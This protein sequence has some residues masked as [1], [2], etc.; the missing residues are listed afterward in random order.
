MP[1]N[2]SKGF[3]LIGVIVAIFIISIGMIGILDLSQSS[4]RAAYLSQTRLIASGL[5]QE[6]IE[7]VRYMRRFQTEWDDWYD[8]V[9]SGNYR[10]QYNNSNL[11]VFSETPL[12]Y[13]TVSGLYQY[14]SGDD[15]PFYR[16]LTLTK[17]SAD[18]IKVVAEIKWQ[19]SGNWHSL[20]A[21]SRL[22]NWK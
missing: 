20:I 21:E 7:V 3:S 14:D 11:L 16:K 12:K 1:K 10:V 18:E 2:N 19:K 17:I 5:A 22:W 15:T 6:G 8:T 13:N 4:L 9:S